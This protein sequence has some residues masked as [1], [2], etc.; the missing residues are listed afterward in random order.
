MNYDVELCGRNGHNG[1]YIMAL[2][3]VGRDVR[4]K[5]NIPTMKTIEK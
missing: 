1:A 3:E 5:F 4:V 2:K